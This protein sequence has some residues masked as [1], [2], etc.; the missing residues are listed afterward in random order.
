MKESAPRLNVLILILGIV[1]HCLKYDSSA[2]KVVNVTCIAVLVASKLPVKVASCDKA[3]R[4]QRDDVN[5]EGL[6]TK[7]HR[8]F[9]SK[10]QVTG[11]WGE[12]LLVNLLLEG[13]RGVAQIDEYSSVSC[14]VS[15][16]LS[17]ERVES[18]LLLDPLPGTSRRAD[19][20]TPAVGT[21]ISTLAAMLG[22]KDLERG[23]VAIAELKT[24]EILG[25][26][27]LSEI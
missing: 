9:A 5:A 22:S 12:N 7:K 20:P 19:P 15:S 3:L 21:L 26:S 6:I 23:L 2:T 8:Q 24:K 16:S 18:L 27:T 4:W 10:L 14:I 25:M 13:P 11:C 17:L 1:R